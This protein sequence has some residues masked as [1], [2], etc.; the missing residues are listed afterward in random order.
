MQRLAFNTWP[1]TLHSS[2]WW[3]LPLLPEVL[4]ICPSFP[5]SCL[6]NLF[7]LLMWWASVD[8]C[9]QTLTTLQLTIFHITTGRL[10]EFTVTLV[11]CVKLVTDC[12]FRFWD[13][14]FQ[15][16]IAA[17]LWFVMSTWNIYGYK[18]YSSVVASLELWKFWLFSGKNFTIQE[19][20]PTFLM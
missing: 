7:C 20:N 1:L 5:C 4:H 2:T 9:T 15:R 18:S 12:V 6:A 3:T 13:R 8:A 11:R 19:E 17:F 14:H 16:V 10:P